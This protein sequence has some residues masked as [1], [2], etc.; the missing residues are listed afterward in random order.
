MQSFRGFRSGTMLSS[1]LNLWFCKR[2]LKTVFKRLR[3]WFLQECKFVLCRVSDFYS[4]DYHCFMIDWLYILHP[5][6]LLKRMRECTWVFFLFSLKECFSNHLGMTCIFFLSLPCF[7][8][9]CVL[10]CVWHWKETH[11]YE[12]RKSNVMLHHFSAYDESVSSI[13]T[14]C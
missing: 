3:H 14:V 13:I 2:G 11:C 7:T 4:W 1:H 5:T 12:M 6:S 10:Q 8:C 9:I